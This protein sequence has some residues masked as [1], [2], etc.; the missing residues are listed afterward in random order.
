MKDAT[1][2]DP[3]IGTLL[4]D[5]KLAG[6]RMTAEEVQLQKISFIMGSLSESS[7][8]TREFVEAELNR[9]NHS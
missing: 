4:E 3:A 5:L 2:D 8:I 1:K 9:L 6:Q 7:G